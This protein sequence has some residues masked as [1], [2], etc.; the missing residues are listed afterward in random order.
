[1]ARFFVTGTD[2][3]AGKTLISAALL[4]KARQQG[5]S[6]F[7]LKPVAA[8]CERHQGQWCNDDAKLLRYY[9]SQQHAYH[10]HNPIALPAAIAPHIAAA[11]QQQTLSVSQLLSV[12]QP[13]LAVEAD[14]HLTE[15]AGGWLVPLND[16][17]QG[18]I[19]T[20]ADFAIRLDVPV[21]LVVGLKLGAINHALLTAQMLMAHQRSVVGWV[22]NAIQPDMQ[23]QT[24]NIQFL[25]RW[26]AQNNIPC[27]GEV[28]HC[29]GI[30][31]YDEQQLAKVAEA[32]SLPADR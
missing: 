19:E 31:A 8:G 6:T 2:T 5:L 9:S 32:L 13:S 18:T 23:V 27:L 21:V 25:R 10:V 28:P 26:F 24:E 12:C 30:D 17:T 4:F 22:A 11:Q 16:G 29:A 3:D 7:G 20:L 15:G 14:F 1:M